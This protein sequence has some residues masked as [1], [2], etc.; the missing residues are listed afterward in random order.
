MQN[1]YA[2][3][4]GDFGKFA[5]LRALA[6]GRR[7]G[8]CW[9]R[10][11][12]E[13]TSTSSDRRFQYLDDPE[14]F[15]DLDRELFNAFREYSDRSV[16]TLE[17]FLV[18]GGLLQDVTF[19]GRACP[20]DFHKRTDWAWEMVRAMEGRDLVFLDPDNGLARKR[21]KRYHA[22]WVELAALRAPTRALVLY[23]HQGMGNGGARTEFEHLQE[24]LK[25]VGVESVEAVR[26]RPYGSRFMYLL[27]GDPELK[28][29]LKTFCDRW[30]REA[31]YFG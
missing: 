8:I 11:D 27:D 15:Q 29:R 26:L 22:A 18:E 2:G 10:V 21:L 9:Y 16:A 19:D 24:R 5:V 23:Q 20:E 30:G 13:A 6:K 25:L 17:R 7:L 28:V 14:R 4:V 1:C 3:D 12:G 31:E